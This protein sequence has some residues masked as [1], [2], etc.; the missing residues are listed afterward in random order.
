MTPINLEGTVVDSIMTTIKEQMAA[1]GGNATEVLTAALPYI[2]GVVGAGVIISIGI[3]WV[4]K[5]KG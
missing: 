3:K 5:I 4:K 2:I 1:L